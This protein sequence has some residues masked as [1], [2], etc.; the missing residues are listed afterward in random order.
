VTIPGVTSFCACAAA[1]NR[2]LTDMN[3]PLHILPASVPELGD[4]LSLRGGKVI[5]KSGSALGEI[6]QLL[7]ERGLSERAALVSDC[8]L[9]TQQICP[10]IADAPEGS[11]FTTILISPQ[12]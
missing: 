4:M 11:Y 6:K 2:S 3:S 7:R 9:P 10:D 5:M 8:G 1:L 12:D